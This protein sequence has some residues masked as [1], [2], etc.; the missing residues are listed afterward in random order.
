MICEYCGHDHKPD[1]FYCIARLTEKTEQAEAE[2]DCAYT[3]IDCMQIRCAELRKQLAEMTGSENEMANRYGAAH[4]EMEIYKKRYE[5]L[6]CMNPD[7]FHKLG[8]ASADRIEILQV[9]DVTTGEDVT[10]KY[11]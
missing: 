1:P 10:E 8:K 5:V 2:R 9:F 4:L 6:R 11:R 3:V 7:E